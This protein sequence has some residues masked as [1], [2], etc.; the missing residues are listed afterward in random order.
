MSVAFLI[1]AFAAHSAF[2]EPLQR[3][4][5][6]SSEQARAAILAHAQATGKGS[7]A[8]RTWRAPPAT[9]A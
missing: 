1:L 6:D 3:L 4:K 2:G 9:T 8:E 5:K 7:H